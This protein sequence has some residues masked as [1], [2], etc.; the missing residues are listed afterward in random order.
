MAKYDIPFVV[1]KDDEIYHE[2][3]VDVSFTKKDIEALEQYIIEHDYSYEFVDV[4][5]YIYDKCHGK[6]FE[7]A[8][9]EFK[10]L[11]YPELG[12]EMSLCDNIP[13]SLL[14]A[15]S[16]ETAEKVMENIPED[17]FEEDEEDCFPEPTKENTL[18]MTIKQVYF[19]QIIA[20]TKTEEYREIKPTTYKKYLEVAENGETFYDMN[21]FLEED[22]A[23][24]DPA[25]GLNIYNNGVCPMIAK[26]NLFYLDLAVG[27]NKVRDTAKVQVVD[28]TFEPQKDGNGNDFRFDIADGGAMVESPN[29]KYCIWIAVLHLGEVVEKN[30]VTK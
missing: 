22:F 12:Y 3:S 27:Y 7:Q 11:A 29:G 13:V 24:Y 18:Y 2:S 23:K 28:I 30:I 10:D 4:P 19:D 20:G 16:E 17:Y 21:V 15:V 1:I 25:W 26:Q 14:S 5:G 6:A 9:K 8:L